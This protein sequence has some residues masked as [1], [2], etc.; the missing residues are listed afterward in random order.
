MFIVVEK[1]TGYI[2]DVIDAIED[3]ND[4]SFYDPNNDELY[5]KDV[6]MYYEMESIPR[7]VHP[8]S[9]GYDPEF[10][11]RKLM[12]PFELMKAKCQLRDSM[13]KDLHT[14]QFQ[15]TLTNK[16]KNYEKEKDY[17]IFLSNNMQNLML[18]LLKREHENEIFLEDNKDAL[19]L[20][21]TDLLDKNMITLEDV[22]ELL[23]NDIEI[24][25]VHLDSIKIEP[26][27]EEEEEILENEW[28]SENIYLN[29]PEIHE[30]LE[31]QP[32]TTMLKMKKEENNEN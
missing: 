32:D 5:T 20:F 21:Y 11:F 30:E 3:N 29:K 4:G 25:Q 6:L 26:Q 19:I 16:I 14:T 17:L 24:F 8:Y 27:E 18:A 31:L 12:T 10:G 2:I 23:K 28:F 7:G 13:R 9:H 1:E 22:P 15:H